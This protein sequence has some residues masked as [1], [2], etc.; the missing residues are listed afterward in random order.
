MSIALS[1]SRDYLNVK[2]FKCRR[3][4]RGNQTLVGFPKVPWGY[5][6]EECLK[7]TPFYGHILRVNPEMW[8]VL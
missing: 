3:E 7:C 8:I 5:S 1:T 2:K 6:M 4:K